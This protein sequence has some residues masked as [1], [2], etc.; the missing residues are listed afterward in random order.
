[1]KLKVPALAL[2]A[3]EIEQLEIIRRAN[4]RE[5]R[6][7]AEIP[8]GPFQPVRGRVPSSWEETEGLP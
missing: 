8:L 3:W 5:S 6:E 2:E 1:M 4:E 7:L